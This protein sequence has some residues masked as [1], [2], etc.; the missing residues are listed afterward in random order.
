MGKKP[1][2]RMR[3]WSGS[4]V[5]PELETDSSGR[6]SNKGDCMRKLVGISWVRQK[7]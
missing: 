6:D 2:K 4:R 5:F 3:R 7:E 1:Q